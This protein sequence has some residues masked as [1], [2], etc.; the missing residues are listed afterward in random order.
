MRSRM[1]LG[2]FVLF[3]TLSA[4]GGGGGGG[5]NDATTATN[6]ADGDTVADRLDN[7]P[8]ESNTDQLDNDADDSGDLCDSDDDNDGVPDTQDA[9]PMDA[10]ETS[11][12]D[13]DGTGDN[14]DPTPKGNSPVA[15]ISASNTANNGEFVVL[16]GSDSSDTESQALQFLWQLTVKPNG[17]TTSISNSNAAQTGFTP[18]LP[19]NY[20]VTL[21]VLDELENQGKT[22]RSIL[23]QQPNRAPQAH[24]SS[25]YLIDSMT[26]LHVLP[27]SFTDEDGDQ[28]TIE[29]INNVQHGT[30]EITDTHGNGVTYQPPEVGFVEETL[31]LRAFDGKE[32]SEQIDIS[33]GYKDDND[34]QIPDFVDPAYASVISLDLIITSDTQLPPGTY[35]IESSL[36]LASGNTLS[37]AAGTDI[38][39]ADNAGIVI[40]GHIMMDGEIDNTIRLLPG[41]ID[42]LGWGE[43]KLSANSPGSTVTDNY[44]Y[45]SGSRIRGVEM[46]G[47]REKRESVIQMCS[48]TKPYFYFENLYMH[49]SIG[50]AGIDLFGKCGSQAKG[51]PIVRNS[52]FELDDRNFKSGIPSSFF[53]IPGYRAVDSVF[54]G[55]AD[56]AIDLQYEGF[57]DH[58]VIDLKIPYEWAY[59]HVQVTYGSHAASNLTNSVIT[60]VMRL[61][62]GFDQTRYTFAPVFKNNLI[63]QLEG[64]YMLIADGANSPE[65]TFTLMPNYYQFTSGE[66]A[67]IYDGND[68]VELQHI[69]LS[70]R[71]NDIPIG[72]GP[73]DTDFDRD[74]ISNEKDARPFNS[75]VQ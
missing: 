73:R 67:G 22:S 39:L 59:H 58:S 15:R 33:I 14:A 65:N 47:F 44:D 64:E 30:L 11:D 13:Q 70:K 17:S 23:I 9:F 19:G 12:I 74:G 49:T 3:L 43:L 75:S 60:A 18:D 32:Y 62:R 25:T 34:N 61:H 53:D 5:G 51:K 37:I 1:H 41:S 72:A 68:N 42:P 38:Y 50:T 35:L 10:T 31:S 20:E 57:I 71:L 45:Q 16:D 27:A 54:R 48:S 36:Q 2:Y 26:K 21:T 55:Y 52:V 56:Q 40:D 28:L 69:D 8:N 63:N 7:C 6:D 46:A 4:C 66:Q 24:F 29:I